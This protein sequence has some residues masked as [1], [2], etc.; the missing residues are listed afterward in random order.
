MLP[1]DL[2]QTFITLPPPNLQASGALKKEI[3]QYMYVE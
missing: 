1:V 2:Q 3:Q